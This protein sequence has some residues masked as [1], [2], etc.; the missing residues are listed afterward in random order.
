MCGIAGI[1]WR[2]EP[3]GADRARVRR[4]TGVIE[5]R[6]PDS[7]GY[8]STPFADVGFRRLSIIDLAGGQQPLSNET[9]T[10][11]CFLNG[12]VYNYKPLRAEL[13]RRG[14]RFTTSSDTEVLPHL[15]EEHGAEM[16]GRLNGMFTVVVVDHTR[17]QLLIARDH[18]GV[19]QMYYSVTPRGV[20]FASEVKAVLASGLVEPV[21]DKR[22]LLGYLT[23]FYCPGPGTLL[24]GVVKLPPGSVLSLRHESGSMKADVQAFYELPR[25]R[26][27]DDMSDEETARRVRELFFDSVERQLQSDVPVGISLSGGVDS[28]AVAYA[29]T[30]VCRRSGNKPPLAVTINWPGGVP[31]E[32]ACAAELARGLG[33]E[34]VEL[35]PPTDNVLGGLPEL[36]WVA[37]EPVADPALY[38]TWC[39]A[40][41]AR[42][43]V[44]VLLAGTGGDEL[45][46]GYGWHK[47]ARRYKLLMRLPATLRAPL[48]RAMSPGNDEFVDAAMDYPKD[49]R[50]FHSLAMSSLG[51]SCRGVL[52]DA[53][54]GS[55]NPYAQIRSYFDRYAAFDAPTQ[56]MVVDLYTYLTEQILPMTD[57]ATMAASIEG[58]VPFLDVP[59]TEFVFSL[60]AR[61][62]LGT[63]EEGKRLLKAA[64]RQGLPASILNRRK[65]GMPSPF[66][67]LIGEQVTLARSV[68]LAKDSYARGILPET[69]LAPMLRDRESVNA[70][71]RVLYS[72]LVLEAWH[73]LFVVERQYDRPSVSSTDL[74]ELSTRELAAM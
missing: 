42:E 32:L 37:D 59:L 1:F 16:F 20:V 24:E 57:R 70:N 74:F 39:V 63:P 68:L 53:I 64:M 29:A 49:R 46:G 27:N 3:N 43:R 50:A 25:T 6:G 56:Q 13:E 52:E 9:G 71:Y 14:H 73:R 69:W 65:A 67:R 40:R 26:P 11:E 62:K 12:E 54:P 4:M 18:F 8:C 17:R 34:Q 61:L 5:H 10:I 33:L 41:A 72:L 48:L 30:E 66:G 60:P 15:Y 47:L 38:S 44:T 51:R 7:D 35:T 28:S 55:Y 23:L 31:E 58:R 19:K 2:D 22:A 45:F 21:I 36:A